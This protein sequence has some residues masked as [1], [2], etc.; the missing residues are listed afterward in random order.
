LEEAQPTSVET[1]EEELN[2]EVGGVDGDEFENLYSAPEQKWDWGFYLWHTA[3]PNVALAKRWQ[4]C[5]YQVFLGQGV[6]L[7][8]GLMGGKEIVTLM[9]VDDDNVAFIN[10]SATPS[11]PLARTLLSK[12]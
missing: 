12:M 4:Q 2:H 10:E 6:S 11:I 3:S 7:S 9:K 8:V 1:P 5:V